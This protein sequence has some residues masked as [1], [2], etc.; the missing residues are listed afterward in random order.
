MFNVQFP[1]QSLSAVTTAIKD[2]THGTHR[3][4][5][6]GVPLL[7]A[8]NITANGEIAFDYTD[9]RIS[10]S[11]YLD[12]ARSFRLEPDDLLLTI[13]GSLGRR[14]IYSGQRITFQRSV[15]YIRPQQQKMRS[16]FLFHWMGHSAFSAEL[17]RRSNA[18]AQAGLYLGELAK[19]SVPVPEVR[20]QKAIAQILDTLDTAIH[21]TEAIIAKLKA[22][23]QGLLHDLLTRGIDANGE[24]RPPQAEAPHLYKES[25]LGWI[26]KEWDISGLAGLAPKDRSVIRTG[27]FGSSLKGEHWRESG[28]PVVT[29]GSLGEAVFIASELLYVDEVTAARLADFELI[30]GDVV[31]SRVADVGRSVV[32]SETER[33]WIMSSN[34]MRISCD[35]AKARPHFLQLLLASSVLVRGQLRTTVN[36]AGRDVAN[37]AVLKG[38]S[39]PWPSPREQ[40]EILRRVHAIGQLLIQEQAQLKKLLDGKSGLM[41]DLLTGR[42]RVTPLLAGAEREKEHA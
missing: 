11:E 8:K 32:V 22:V 42:V 21:E 16:R 20:E 24:L 35:P 27:P 30:P 19:V 40:D 2:G 26:P 9:D 37:S 31:F 6:E 34:F 41:D 18:T 10:E 39:F 1:T 13:V 36:S 23:K 25:P 14:A 17:K 38:L 12:L 28:S 33:G 7:S 29:I 5:A 3:R 15:A 4:V